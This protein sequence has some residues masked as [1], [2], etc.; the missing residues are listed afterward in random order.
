MQ[1]MVVIDIASAIDVS[2]LA[3]AV[4]FSDVSSL[5][6]GAPNE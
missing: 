1:S 2:E 5:N 6:P 4:V 3:V